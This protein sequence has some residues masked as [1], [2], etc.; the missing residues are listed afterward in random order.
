L[1]IWGPKLKAKARQDAEDGMFGKLARKVQARPLVAALGVAGILAAAALPFLHV[2]YGLGDPRTLPASSQSHQAD[3]TPL[4]SLP[5]MGADPI[6]VAA[7]IP[8]SDPRVGAY[9]ASLAHLPGVAAVSAEHGLH[10][11]VSVI[12]VTPAGS[13]QGSTAQH[14]VGVLRGHRPA[15][16]TY[17]TG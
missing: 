10:G 1:A 13:T 14:L 6:Q 9:A 7:R 15:F 12:D 17:V 5:A 11:N 16:R 2:N 8:A 3:Q 4:A